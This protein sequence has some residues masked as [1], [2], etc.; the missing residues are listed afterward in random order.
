MYLL[1]IVIGLL[2]LGMI[3]RYSFV[4]SLVYILVP[5]LACSASLSVFGLFHIPLTLFSVLAMMLVLGISMDY[6]IFLAESHDDYKGTMLALSLS[7]ITTILSFGLLSLSDTPAIHYFGLT[8]LVG[9]V[10]AFL[11]SPIAIKVK[12]NEN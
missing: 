11:I 7:A 6:V 10:L 4:Q 5:I 3:V 1:A 8:V 9:I 12:K 2:W